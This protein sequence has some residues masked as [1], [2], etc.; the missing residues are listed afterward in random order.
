MRASNNFIRERLDLCGDD[1]GKWS[2][3]W[4]EE[5]P[6]GVGSAA[7]GARAGLEFRECLVPGCFENDLYELGVVPDPFFGVNP[8]VVNEYAE[9]RHVCYRVTFNFVKKEFTEP[10]LIFEGLDCFADIYINGALAASTDNM[11]IEHAIPAG[12]YLFDG[13]NELF[14]H[15]RPAR[16]EALKF[17][18][19]QFV[20]SLP[21]NMESVYVRKAAHMYGWDIMPRFISAGI[22]RPVYIEYRPVERFEE[23]YL[24]T[25]GVS[26][27]GDSADLLLHYKFKGN[28]RQPYRLRIDMNCRG[29]SVSETVEPV[30][31]AGKLKIKMTGPKLWRPV[32][33]GEAHLY[34]VTVSLYKNDVLLDSARFKHGVRTVALER[35]PLTTSAMDG[36]FVF[37]VNGEK[38]F[39]K[40]TNWV[41]ADAFHFRDRGRIPAILE[42]ARDLNCN[43]IRCWGGN[44]YEDELFYEICDESGILVWQDFG[45]ACSIYPQDDAFLIKIAAE[46]EAVVKRLRS[47]ACVILWSGDNE[48]DQAYGWGGSNADPNTNLLT[49]KILPEA[50]RIHDG[51]RPYIGSSPF[52]DGGAGKNEKFLTETHLWGPKNYFK[53]R[54]YTDSLYHFV[55]EIGYHGCP[56]P[57]SVAKFIS[58]GKLWPW[59]DNDEWAM[60]ASSPLPGVYDYRIPLMA[61]QIAELFAEIPDNLAD[62]SFASQAVQ[63]EAKKFFIEMFRMAKWK[64]TGILWWNL[65]DGW[66]QFSDAVVDYYFNKKLAYGFIKN[67]QLDVCVALGEPDGWEQAVVALNDTRS[68][69]VID[70]EI[71][72]LDTDEMIFGGTFTARADRS[73]VIGSIPFARNKKR[74]FVIRWEGE[75]S[76]INHYLAGQPPFTLCEYRRWLELSG[77]VE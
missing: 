15:I 37:S 19:P 5:P 61:K 65:M 32:G 50:V 39:I 59:K 52:L 49:R 3:A 57:E 56:A 21:M 45:M 71:T 43:M 27:D 47:H 60:H 72:D 16:E 22:F 40:G 29:S 18:Y 36:E 53:S 30:F 26:E 7:D 33:R 11:L 13:G 28:L 4:T 69:V 55:S 70:C 9:K 17:E 46:A 14:V 58:A 25:V 48:C 41:P 54:Y 42:M 8:R 74:F 1:L 77:V 12:E 20:D 75:A 31:T 62:F 10:Y 44:V 24:K 2:F 66:P 38:I 35:T 73:A 6:R 67:S 34:D 76:G 51:S 23:V 64:R 63:A 68:D